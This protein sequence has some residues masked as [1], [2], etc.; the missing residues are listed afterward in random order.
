MA[1]FSGPSAPLGESNSPRLLPVGENT[2]TIKSIPCWFTTNCRYCFSVRLMLK[3]WVS[4]EP[5]VRSI[6]VSGSNVVGVPLFWAEAV[7]N[8][9]SGRERKVMVESRI[10]NLH[11]RRELCLGMQVYEGDY[12]EVCLTSALLAT[13]FVASTCRGYHQR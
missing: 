4:A 10:S 13:R 8:N 12:E 7:M 3:L 11:A 2:R 1:T 9:V 5:I 6:G